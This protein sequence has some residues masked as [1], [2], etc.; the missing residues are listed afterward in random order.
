VIT[1]DGKLECYI[2]GDQ[3]MT[4]GLCG[5]RTDF[6]VEEDNAQIHQCLNRE[7]RYQFIAAG[8]EDE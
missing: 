4:C 6:D 2:L 5:A 7:C 8:E 1:A 3:P